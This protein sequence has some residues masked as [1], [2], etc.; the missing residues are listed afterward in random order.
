MG[1]AGTGACHNMPRHLYWSEQFIDEYA[2]IW[3][4]LIKVQLGKLNL[5]QPAG[6]YIIRKLAEN[7]IEV[8]PS[9]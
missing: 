8:L 4:I 9:L 2:S 6:P 7:R 3:E 1:I 5:P